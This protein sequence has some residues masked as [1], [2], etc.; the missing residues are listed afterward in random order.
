[1]TARR[2]PLFE[3]GD[4]SDALSGTTEDDRLWG[5]AGGDTLLGGLGADRLRGMRGADSLLGG[6]GNDTLLGGRG[7]DTLDGG[8]GDDLLVG[9]AGADSF[10]FGPEGGDDVAMVD[11]RDTV[12]IDAGAGSIRI[13][14]TEAGTMRF[15]L[16]DSFGATTGSVTLVGGPIAQLELR[17][18]AISGEAPPGEGGSTGQPGDGGGTLVVVGG[19][20][21]LLPGRLAPDGVVLAASGRDPVLAPPAEEPGSVLG[22]GTFTVA[23]ITVNAITTVP[24]ILVAAPDPPPLV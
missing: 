4:R 11:A 17:A 10:R 21:T 1:M 18:G 3:G 5:H 24:V 19:G 13:E 9:G 8:A 12:L 6:E 16:L 15:V 2:R 22:H 20:T 23:A 7:N 14:T